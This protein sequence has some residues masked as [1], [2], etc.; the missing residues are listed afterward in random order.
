MTTV[1]FGLGKEGQQDVTVLFGYM[2]SAKQLESVGEVDHLGNGRPSH[3]ET[4]CRRLA[5]DSR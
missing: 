5:Y 2:I 3:G 4:P 1:F